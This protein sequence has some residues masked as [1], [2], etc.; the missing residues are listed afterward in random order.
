MFSWGRSSRKTPLAPI[1][2]AQGA[3]SVPK[4]VPR[5]SRTS[6]RRPRGCSRSPQGYLETA[7]GALRHSIL[8]PMTRPKAVLDAL[9]GTLGSQK[10]SLGSKGDAFGSPIDQSGRQAEVLKHH[11]RVVGILVLSKRKTRFHCYG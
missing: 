5:T 10:A 6:P 9:E 1:K 7:L 11:F 8:I 4:R 3:M 2:H